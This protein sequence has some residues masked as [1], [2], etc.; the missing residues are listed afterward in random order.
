[1]KLELE[2][3]GNG[4]RDRFI[5]G[6]KNLWQIHPVSGLLS[7]LQLKFSKICLNFCPTQMRNSLQLFCLQVILC[8]VARKECEKCDCFSNRGRW[9]CVGRYSPSLP[10]ANWA[11]NLVSVP[12]PVFVFSP[13]FS[14]MNL[15]LYLLRYFQ[16]VYLLTGPTITLLDSSTTFETS[17]ILQVNPRPIFL[18]L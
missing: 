17:R 4:D 2:T 16:P 18:D 14:K 3:V 5:T 15:N 13:V 11:N 6:V 8:W 1:M 7:K 9:K 12:V 10:E